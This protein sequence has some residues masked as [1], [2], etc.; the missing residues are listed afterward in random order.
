M[1]RPH[2]DVSGTAPPSRMKRAHR[3]RIADEHGQ[4]DGADLQE[5]LPAVAD[6]LA[7]VDTSRLYHYLPENLGCSMAVFLSIFRARQGIAQ[8][9]L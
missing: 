1:P 8:S 4:H 7:V 6:D 3:S 9:V 2:H 5:R